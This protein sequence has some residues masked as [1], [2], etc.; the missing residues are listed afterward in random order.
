[1]LSSKAVVHQPHA[2]LGPSQIE[3]GLVAFIEEQIENAEIGQ[4]AKLLLV[5]LVIRAGTE[6]SVGQRMFRAD[7]FAVISP[8]RSIF[9]D[10]IGRKRGIQRFV[11][12]GGG[13]QF[14]VFV[15]T[16]QCRMDVQQLTH[17]LCNSQV[18]V[19]QKLPPFFKERP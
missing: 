8:T 4:E 17:L 1:M 3:Y 12:V 14:D 18:V 2:C 15:S 16:A 6:I 7:D 11:A 19:Q 5:D 10:F 9:S 13:A